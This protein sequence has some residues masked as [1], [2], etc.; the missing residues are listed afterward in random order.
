MPPPTAVPQAVDMVKNDGSMR[1]EG[2]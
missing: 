2:T 1:H